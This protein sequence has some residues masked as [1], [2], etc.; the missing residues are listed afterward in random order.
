MPELR[1]KNKKGMY[2]YVFSNKESIT[3]LV[4][5]KITMQISELV[6]DSRQIVLKASVP[7]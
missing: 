7:T 4:D 2:N 5:L 3:Q 1:P 6:L